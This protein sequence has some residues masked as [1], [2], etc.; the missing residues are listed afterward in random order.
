MDTTAKPKDSLLPISKSRS[1]P[2]IVSVKPEHKPSKR[3]LRSQKAPPSYDSTVE[4]KVFLGSSFP[5]R[6]MDGNIGK[7]RSFNSNY[8]AYKKFAQ[9]TIIGV[10]D[11]S[12]TGVADAPVNVTGVA[13]ASVTGVADAPVNVTGVADASVTGVADAPVTGV[14][15]AP[16]TGVADA[17]LSQKRKR[18][19]SG[20]MDDLYQ[21]MKKL[22]TEDEVTKR[23]LLVVHYM[24]QQPNLR[25]ITVD[26]NTGVVTFGQFL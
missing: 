21:A 9:T 18:D 7:T 6:I 11:A 3:W 16:V 5:K 15:D 8:S 26:A 23:L 19:A 2:G 22:K 20:Q 1:I 4:R 12:V 25:E 10:A 17:S 24:N 14:A 13:D